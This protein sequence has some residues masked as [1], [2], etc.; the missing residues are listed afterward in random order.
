MQASRQAIK[1]RRQ[2]SK[3]RRQ[4][5]RH[6]GKQ[7]GKQANKQ[8]NKQAGKQAGKKA[9]TRNAFS[10]SHAL[11]GLVLKEAMVWLRTLLILTKSLNMIF[12][13][14]PIMR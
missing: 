12:S 11:E 5:S 6:A 4:A 8:A 13:K 7:A 1:E 14:T 10:R 9:S 2:A 3:E